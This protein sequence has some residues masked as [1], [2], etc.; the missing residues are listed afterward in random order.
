MVVETGEWVLRAKNLCKAFTNVPAVDGVSIDLKKGECLAL[1]GPNGAGKTTTCEML[2]GL[3][4]WDAGSISLFDLPLKQNRKKIL[5]R[6]GVQLQETNLYKKYTVRE[7]L[8]LFASFYS[9]PLSVKNLIAKLKLEDKEDS[10]L[11]K[12]SGGQRQRVYLGCSLVND[13]EI[14]FLDEPTTGLDPQARRYIWDMLLNLKQ[15]GRSILLTTHYM[16]EAQELAD[17]IAIMDRGTIIASGT[18][19]ELIGQY[20]EGGYLSFALS[21]EDF[22]RL[23]EQLP[24]LENTRL[25][26]NLW[27]INVKSTT[28]KTRE[29]MRGV[30][31]LGVDLR[32]FA[33]RQGSLEDVFL[34]LTGRSIRD[35]K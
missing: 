16:E 34:K 25:V 31:S 8:E 11:E 3:I 5:E 24:W 29:L 2:E 33:I 15:E 17:R 18:A 32:Q 30:D 19:R 12:L 27:Q 1:L 22:E 7:T 23:K 20:C 13:P 14:V 6:I 10:R 35:D 4:D 26:N 28:Q 21:P 9:N